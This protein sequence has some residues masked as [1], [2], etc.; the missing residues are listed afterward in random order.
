M[1]AFKKKIMIAITIK[2]IIKSK[3]FGFSFREKLCTNSRIIGED[4]YI[5]E[6]LSSVHDDGDISESRI[7]RPCTEDKM[8]IEFF[9][10]D[11]D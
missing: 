9:H 7:L 5:V 10:F 8:R 3:S 11:I 1:P 4:E 2:H 6:V